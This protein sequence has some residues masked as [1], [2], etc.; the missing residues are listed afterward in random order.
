[1]AAEALEV[2]RVEPVRLADPAEVLAELRP[3]ALP[4]ADADVGVVALR[5]HPRVP[6]RDVGELE[7][8]PLRVALLRRIV[9]GT[10]PS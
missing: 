8:E 10:F 6:A 2:V 4:A 5:E 9:Y 3:L 1:M 7:H